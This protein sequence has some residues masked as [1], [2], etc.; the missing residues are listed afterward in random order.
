MHWI[1]EALTAICIAEFRIRAL[2]TAY[3]LIQHAFIPIVNG[4]TESIHWIDYTRLQFLLLGVEQRTLI[5]HI[6]S[7]R[8]KNLFI[9]TA[10][11][12]DTTFTKIECSPSNELKDLC[13]F[14]STRI[15][16]THA[17]NYILIQRFSFFPRNFLFVFNR[18]I[19]IK[20]VLLN[21]PLKEVEKNRSIKHRN[22]NS[23]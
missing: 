10:Y 12:N 15:S 23:M 1:I 19:V 2:S 4:S 11:W 17:I 5:A 6:R 13:L 8:R 14:A 7:R 22:K 18:H 16:R 9:R 21:I 3:L 20:A